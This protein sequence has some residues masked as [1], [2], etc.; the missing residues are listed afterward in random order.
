MAINLATKYSGKID[1]T[2]INGAMSAP[3][4]NNDYDWVGT[5]TVKVYS[6]DPVDMNNYIANGTNRYGTPEELQDTTQELTLKNKRSFTF[7]IDK[8]HKIDTPEGVRDAAKALRRQID[9]VIVPEL[10]AYRFKVIAD[11]AGTK[12]IV[13]VDATN[14]YEVFLAANQ[15]IDDKDI[16]AAGRVANVSPEF[17]NLIKRD[18]SFIKA[19]DLS[20][21]ILIK[22]Q[23]G[24]IDGV[25]I[26]KVASNRL[27]AGL[28]FEITHKAACVAPVKLEE[29]KIHE[30]PPGIAGQ[31]VEGLI[32]YDA[33]VL[34][35]KKNMVSVVYG[36]AGSLNVTAKTGGDATHSII[37]ISGNTKGGKLVYKGDYASESSALGA[38]DLGDNVSSWSEVPAN[39]KVT[40]SSGKY[41]AVAV[42]VDGKAVAGGA[43]AAVVTG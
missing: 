28:S 24:E 18:D 13:A 29:Y 20:Q 21:G 7:T 38:V 1:E 6:F 8:T 43:V 34:N 14:A 10:D 32:Y 5:Q 19:G 4:V 39:G 27:P 37:T 31:L 9:E 40:T 36:K 11:E 3:S 23:V 30:D 41:I 12:N 2:I 33:F 26:V 17:Y 22:G 42:A 16:P 35:K 15:A 25:A